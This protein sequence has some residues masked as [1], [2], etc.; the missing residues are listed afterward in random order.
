MTTLTLSLAPHAARLRRTPWRRLFLVA[1]LMFWATLALKLLLPADL[2]RRAHRVFLVAPLFPFAAKDLSHWPDALARSRAAWA[3]RD[4]RAQLAAWLPPEFVGL[5]RLG[6]AQ[7]RGLLCW[8]LRRPA[9]AQPAGQAFGYLA[10]GSYRTAFAIVLVAVLVEL[11]LDAFIVQWLANTVAERRAIHALMLA[12]GLSTLA[13]VLGDRW[14]IGAGR[15]VLDAESLHLRVGARTRGAVPRAA[16]RDCRRFDGTVAA[17]CRTH[18]IDPMHAL[19]VSPLDKP[20]TVLILADDSP[21]RPIRIT[22]LGREQRAP[23][24]VFLYL[25]RPD[26]LASA[27][28]AHIS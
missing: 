5:M 28:H 8:L 7:R 20:N 3:S 9:P 18:D 23:A 4:W 15:H 26:D 13:W 12:G 21:V 11:P 14:W 22:H 16:I 2:A 6:A 10:Q 25:D 1:W 17:W 19:K 27:L 24:C